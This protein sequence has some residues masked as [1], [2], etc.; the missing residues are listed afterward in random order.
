MPH[1]KYDA[2][3]DKSQTTDTSQ[4]TRLNFHLT[5]NGNYSVLIFLGV[6]LI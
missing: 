4:E 1:S 5:C 3:S 2:S 6:A